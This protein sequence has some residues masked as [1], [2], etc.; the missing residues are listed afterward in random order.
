MGAVAARAG[1][2]GGDHPS[3][4]TY[5]RTTW[6]AKSTKSSGSTQGLVGSG[7]R[8]RAA[9]VKHSV[10]VVSPLGLAVAGRRGPRRRQ[11]EQAVPDDALDAAQQELGRALEP[12]H[13]ERPVRRHDG[14]PA[15][16]GE[17]HVVARDQRPER[18]VRVPVEAV[19][20]GGRVHVP[21]RD[22]PA[23]AAGGQHRRLELRVED[24]DPAGLDHQVGVPC[25]L[26][27]RERVR[28]AGGIDDH[29]RPRGIGEVAVGLPVVGVGLVEGH[30]VA[31]RVERAHESPVVRRRAVPVRRDQ[32]RPEERD[33]EPGRHAMLARTRTPASSAWMSRSSST[34]WAQV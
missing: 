33:A 11:V 2:P 28:R 5:R 29:A 25:G 4:R 31:A 30:P 21:E 7:R 22:Q 17:D 18:V 24:A 6:R 1:A 15:T 10:T 16:V 8:P 9:G 13:P 3:P 12:E 23:G 19:E 32:A 20:G 14:R 34:R 26:D 27:R